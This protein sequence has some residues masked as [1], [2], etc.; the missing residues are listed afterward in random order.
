VLFAAMLDIDDW[1]AA[2]EWIDQPCPAIAA[3]EDAA[4]L[5]RAR[6]STGMRP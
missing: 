5:A 1:Q 3:E 4:Q 2:V 6:A